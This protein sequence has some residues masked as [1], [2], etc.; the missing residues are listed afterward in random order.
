VREWA[1]SIAKKDFKEWRRRQTKGRL[2]FFLTYYWLHKRIH[3]T[4]TKI[5]YNDLEKL[6]MWGRRKELLE[7]KGLKPLF[8]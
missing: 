4:L 1:S 7:R 2:P 8:I 3:E 5:G 6:L